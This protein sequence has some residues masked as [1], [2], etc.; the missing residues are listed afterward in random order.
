MV[1]LPSALHQ[2]SR[3]GLEGLAE[4]IAAQRLSLPCQ[5][6]SLT[7]LVPTP[8][9]RVIA[10]ELNQLHR[11]GMHA[12]H[13]AYLLQLLAQE[14]RQAQEQRNCIDLVWTGQE[15]PGSES[16]DTQV[17]VQELF[18]SATQS[19][20]MSSYALDTGP[21]A[22]ALFQPLAERMAALPGLNVRL[23]INIQRV[24]GD[25]NTSDAALLRQ[26]AESFRHEIWPGDRLPEVFYDPQSLAK[27]IGP[28]ACLHAKCVVVD[29]ER[30]FVTS[31]NFTEAAHQRNIEAGVLIA[32]AVAARAMVAQFETLVARNFLLR[33]PGL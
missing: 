31:A 11:E 21:K 10:Q 17:V 23:F 29:D 20:L 13:V 9:L 15:V 28:R 8:W 1:T 26:F 12:Q 32:D 30:L 4:A 2:L 24:Y 3:P 22:Q 18:R 25:R 33:V 5:A 7:S 27:A 14:R 6:A 16:R 19:L